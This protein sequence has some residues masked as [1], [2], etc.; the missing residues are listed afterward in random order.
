MAGLARGTAEVA[1][2]QVLG[3]DGYVDPVGAVLQ[4]GGVDLDLPQLVGMSRGRG[5]DS[6]DTK[7]SKDGNAG[8]GMDERSDQPP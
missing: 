1:R 4:E 6:K 3:V 7:D 8:A 5:K 2:R